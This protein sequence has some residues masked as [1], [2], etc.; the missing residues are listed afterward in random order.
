[1]AWGVN[2]YGKKAA[3]LLKHDRELFVSLQTNGDADKV[4]KAAEEVRAAH[5]RVLKSEVARLTP[6]EKNA[7]TL[8]KLETDM[9][10]WNAVSVEEIIEECRKKGAQGH[11]SS[12]PIRRYKRGAF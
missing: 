3:Q 11:F 9:A 10:Q 1:M 7:Q 6:C 5:I 2:Y 12:G 8:A 4:L